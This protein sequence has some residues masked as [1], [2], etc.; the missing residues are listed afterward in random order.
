MSRETAPSNP[1]RR[2]FL[3]VGAAAS[4][5]LVVGWRS[6]N[7][8]EALPYLG[9]RFE[10]QA[11][12]PFVRIEPNGDIVL[13]ARGCET[14]TGV[15][16]LLPMLVAEELDVDWKRVRVEQ[17]PYGY[18]DTDKGPIDRY[19]AQSLADGD[20]LPAGWKDLRLAGATARQRLIAAAA[21]RWN[22]DAGTLR[23]DAGSVI[24]ADGRRLAYAEL[25]GAAAAIDPPAA[26]PPLKKPADF[27]IIGQAIG[28]VDAH[29]VVTGQAEFGSDAYRS[30]MLY[31]VVV[32]CPWTD[33]TLD[34]L[35]DGDARRVAGVK[36]I[37]RIAGPKPDE[38]VV[39][40]QTEAVAVLATSTW[41]A[42]KARDKLKIEWKPGAWGNESSEGMHRRADELLKSGAENAVHVRS[43][44][45]LAKARKQARKTIEARYTVPFLAHAALEPPGALI[46][47]QKDR[48]LLIASLQNPDGA[49][50]LLHDLTGVARANIDIRLPRA[51]GSFTRRMKNDFVAEA[52]LIAQ[53]TDKPVKLL[54]TRED[55]LQHDFYRPFGVHQLLATVDRKNAITGWSHRCAAT[56]RH[57]REAGTK[58]LPAWN[59]CLVPDAFPANLVEHFELAFYPIDSGVLRGDWPGG[60]HPFTTFAVESFIDEVADELKQDPLKLRLKL[61]GAPRE[62]PYMDRGGPVFD[63][64]RMAAVLQAAA[65]KIGWGRKPDRDH[66]LGIASHF[67]FGVYAAHAFEVSAI[68]GNVV[69]HR[70]VCAIDAGRTVNPLDL[71]AQAIGATID[72]VST[73]LNLGITLKDGKVQQAGFADYPVLRM[74]QAPAEVEVVVIESDRDPLGATATCG[75][76]AAPALVNAIFT[77]SRLRVRELPVGYQL[78]R[79]L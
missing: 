58:D 73:A 21:A 32:R 77:A 63:T 27:K 11:L 42:L 55:D 76:S 10:A 69:I 79:I 14:G 46:H 36:D 67:T 23:T 18:Q 28:T 52:A 25:V 26:T 72:G 33:G 2:R 51:G 37:L 71:E 43:D 65:D 41:A 56:P 50:Q 22:V 75:A 66:G 16:T 44:G 30:E 54:W 1:S 6:G 57:Y 9:A 61:L 4:G 29:A 8:Q 13:G 59:G 53:H 15:K 12:G 48:I 78:R 24:A 7:A 47:V 34:S 31:A 45:D 17:L 3:V 19:G 5:A 35:D 64:G 39:G 60:A 68:D 49:S 38:A 62:L 40:V 70:A 20:A 74:S